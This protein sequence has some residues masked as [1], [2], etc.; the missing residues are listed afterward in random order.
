MQDAVY[1]NEFALLQ[2]SVPNPSIACSEEAIRT[3]PMPHRLGKV[4]KTLIHSIENVHYVNG[5]KYILLSVS[6]IYDKEN[7]VKF[8]SKTFTV[9]NLVTGEVVLMTKRFKNIYVAD[10]ESLNNGDITFLSVVD[11]DVEL[12]HRRLGYVSF[13]LLNKLVKKDLVRGL[14]KSRSKDHKL[15]DACVRGKQVRSSFG[16]I[17]ESKHFKATDH[18]HMDLCR[19]MRVPSRGGNKYI[20]VIV[21]DYCRFTW[22]L[23]LRTKDETFSNV[24]CHYEVD[25]SEDEP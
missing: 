1:E 13:S 5:L 21:D 20:F 2:Q 9:T 14:P 25:S 6:Q 8:L 15:C 4:G 10:F 3:T 16:P 11:D 7:K 17:N 19:P 23:I 18:Y 24:C 22:T 12:W